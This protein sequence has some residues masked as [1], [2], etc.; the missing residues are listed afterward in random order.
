MVRPAGFETA[1]FGSGDQRSKPWQRTE[2]FQTSPSSLPLHGEYFLRD[3]LEIRAEDHM[4]VGSLPWSGTSLPPGKE[5]VAARGASS[6]PRRPT[7][8]QT[9]PPFL[10]DGNDFSNE[11]PVS[12]F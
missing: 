1:T 10:Q 9:L 6:A 12:Y 3:T 2:A 4:I 8:S 11:V 5:V 7:R